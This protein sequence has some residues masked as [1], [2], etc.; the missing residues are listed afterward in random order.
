MRME[1][2]AERP[3]VCGGH[4]VLHILEVSKNASL[5]P[6]TYISLLLKKEAPR[7]AI[8]SWSC[9]SFCTQSSRCELF[10]PKAF[11]TTVMCEG[12]S[13]HTIRL[14]HLS[15]QKRP[16][17]RCFAFAYSL[18]KSSYVVARCAVFEIQVRFMPWYQVCKPLCFRPHTGTLN[19]STSLGM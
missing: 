1:F 2:R 3:A 14:T 10:V 8:S 9:I 15:C 18:P 19:V 13:S 12:L 17:L 7:T 6:R 16:N 11:E 4:E 5:S